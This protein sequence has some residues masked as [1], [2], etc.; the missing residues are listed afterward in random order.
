MPRILSRN[1]FNRRTLSLIISIG[2]LAL[3][4]LPTKLLDFIQPTA[5]AAATFTVNSTGDGADSNLNDGVCDDGTGHCTL[6]A[7]IQQANATPGT[8]T[9][10]FN[11]G[12]G[13]LQ[14]I[15]LA[16][17]PPDVTDPVVIDGTTQPGY[18]GAPL[19]EILGADN[20]QPPI[21]W[22]LHITAG[23]STVRGL[24]I[25]RVSVTGILLGGFGSGGRGG[26]KVES[27]YIGLRADG[28]TH[29]GIGGGCVTAAD[30]PNNVVGGMNSSTRNVLSGC[31]AGV[32]I[33]GTLST[34]N[35]V[36]G[37]YLG[38]NSSGT[39]AL[40]T[41]SGGGVGV[42]LRSDASNNII[43]GTAAGD[44]NVISG[45]LF[46][47]VI[48]VNTTS[49][50]RIQGNLIGVAA[51]GKTVVPNG[52]NGVE[53]TGATDY[54]IGGT[55]VGAGNLISGN[56]QHGV[57]VTGGTGNSIQG[58]YIGTDASGAAAIP[59]SGDGVLILNASNNLIGGDTPA[60]RN[61]ISG[62]LSNGVEVRGDS[63]PGVSAASSNLIEGNY[64]GTNAAGTAPLGNTGDDVHVGGVNNVIGG[65]TPT[66]GVAPGNLISGSFTHIF[67]IG[68][69]TI[70]QGNLVGTDAS[71]TSKLMDGSFGIACWG[72]QTTIGGTQA[73]SRNVI[74]GSSS[75]NADGIEVANGGTAVIQGNFI[76]TDISGSAVI[77]NRGAGIEVV[78][79]G[80]T[81]GGTTPAAGNVISG[82][83][84]GISLSGGVSTVQ[85]NLIGTDATGTAPLGNTGD[86]V[87]INLAAHNS[88]VGGTAAGAGNVIAFNGG[89]G[90]A[91]TP[92]SFDGS[93]T[94]ANALR[95]NS[96]FS[97]ALLGI[98]LVA[99]GPPLAA[100][101]AHDGL[102]LN[103]PG[104]ADMGPNG[105]QNSPVV[106]SVTT[107][108][109]TTSVQG[110]LNSK[111]N[112]SF[113]ID[114]YVNAVCDASGAG[115]GQAFAGSTTATTDANGDATFSATFPAPSAGQ[116]ITATAT[117][118]AGN[119]SEFSVCNLGSAPGTGRIG[120]KRV[121]TNQ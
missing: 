9:I 52:T 81:I 39:A 30:S 37:N 5:H 44:G 97:N 26:N 73:G 59:N 55:A 93:F 10:N 108:G 94:S 53:L 17:T 79:L 102:T 24:A 117:D 38:T 113:T 50:N 68:T 34:G 95:G 118:A 75:G 41:V 74:S 21:S 64:V 83:G 7:A 1:E 67:V 103:D 13:G 116:I 40:S 90:I 87:R 63:G 48:A 109:G 42:E 78:S 89:A 18:S 92:N 62:N 49:G 115:E 2:A 12:S 106:L 121:F 112:A 96:V 105:L 104:D 65:L 11:I 31:G 69:G 16:T 23:S 77:G 8:D 45:N 91:V 47:G 119:T 57:I 111:P 107:S 3:V 88:M 27:C 60:A 54:L 35:V 114:F 100:I 14:T 82:N 22:A 28:I 84:T 101:P 51:D 110:T 33:A 66:P 86:G 72:P 6:R 25:G 85:G 29:A 61:V 32:D 71:G 20:A 19:I 15:T 120:T 56:K 36:Q 46:S 80:V 99:P 43:G 70:I 76:G 4:A 58:N 98:D